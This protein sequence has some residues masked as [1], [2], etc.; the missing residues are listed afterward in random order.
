MKRCVFCE[1]CKED[2]HSQVL[3][4]IVNPYN[5]IEVVVFEPYNPCVEGH[6]LFVPDVHTDNM[7]G[8]VECTIATSYAMHIYA[9]A[10]VQEH[11]HMI[12][13]NGKTAEQTI[14]HMHFHFIPRRDGDGIILPWSYQKMKKDGGV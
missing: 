12:A 4:R 9:R 11:F 6:L 8:D 10:V 3:E 2:P 7:F 1:I 13:N 14:F 5:N